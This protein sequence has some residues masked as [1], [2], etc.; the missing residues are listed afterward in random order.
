MN[1]NV[2]VV[3]KDAHSVVVMDSPSGNFRGMY[4]VTSGEIVGSPQQSGN[5]VTITCRE[6]G[7]TWVKVYTLPQMG[8]VRQNT[9]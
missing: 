3:V 9:V 7:M 8:L 4:F 6:S 1:T 2:T 5:T